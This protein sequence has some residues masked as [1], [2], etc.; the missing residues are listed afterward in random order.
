MIFRIF[1]AFLQPK[2]PIS[3][4]HKNR[5]NHDFRQNMTFPTNERYGLICIYMTEN[6]PLGSQKHIFKQKSF[7]TSFKIIFTKN[8]FLRDFRPEIFKINLQWLKLFLKKNAAL[9]GLKWRKNHGKCGKLP[10]FRFLTWMG[11][12]R[13]PL[14]LTRFHFVLHI[15][16][17]F[18]IWAFSQ[19][20]VLWVFF[21]LK[22]SY[23]TLKFCLGSVSHL[24]PAFSYT[25]LGKFLTKKKLFHFEI[26]VY[27]CYSP[28]F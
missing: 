20:M 7:S 27:L 14:C 4:S 18:I 25:L 9:N 1:H 15:F 28:L 22:K 8:Q 26:P 13:F 3:K 19:Y 17:K 6:G 10:F 21:Q 23:G 5:K 16:K 2:R 12:A 11:F 24:C